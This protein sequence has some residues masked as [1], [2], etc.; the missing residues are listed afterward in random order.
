VLSS[1]GNEPEL[2]ISLFKKGMQ[3]GR[4]EKKNLDEIQ[5]DCDRVVEVRFVGL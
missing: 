3:T 2:I 1:Q 5:F 4:N